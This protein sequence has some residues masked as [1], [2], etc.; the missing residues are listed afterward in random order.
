MTFCLRFV[1]LGIISGLC[2][3]HERVR[4]LPRRHAWRTAVLF[5]QFDSPLL[6]PRLESNLRDGVDSAGVS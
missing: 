4:P 3:R 6:R 5:G 1:L 2:R